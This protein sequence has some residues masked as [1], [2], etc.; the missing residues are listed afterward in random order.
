MLRNN[1]F[2][3]SVF[4]LTFHLQVFRSS[5]RVGVHPIFGEGL[6]TCSQ[7]PEVFVSVYVLDA[8]VEAFSVETFPV[9]LTLH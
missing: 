6:C 8:H 3:V 1:F 9:V 5:R 7:P 4:D 2:E